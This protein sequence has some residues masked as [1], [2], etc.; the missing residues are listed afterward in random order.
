MACVRYVHMREDEHVKELKNRMYRLKDLAY[1]AIQER[2]NTCV[3]PNC[4]CK[5]GQKHGP[6][7]Y[8]SFRDRNGKLRNIYLKKHEVKNIEQKLKKFKELMNGLLEIQENMK[9]R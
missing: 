1:G 7:Y 6:Y 2:M 5:I 3:R 9:G 4:K 8:L